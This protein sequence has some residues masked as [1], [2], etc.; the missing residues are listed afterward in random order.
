M[1]DSIKK[2]G[3]VMKANKP[4]HIHAYDVQPDIRDFFKNYATIKKIMENS[5]G[6]DFVLFSELFLISDSRTL[7]DENI[8]QGYKD[9]LNNIKQLAINNDIGISFGCIKEVEREFYICQTVYLPDGRS[10]E[11][12]KT[13]L[14]INERLHFKAGKEM[15][16]FNYKGYN[17]STQICIETHINDLSIVHRKA[18]THIVLAPFRTPYSVE[19]RIINWEKYIPTRGYD[20]NMCFV[21][22]NHNGGKFCV[23]GKGD[24][25]TEITI[26]KNQT[27]L[28]DQSD[29]NSKI[30][31]MSYRQEEL[32]KG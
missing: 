26:G 7:L 24:I 12:L 17:F 30:D 16:Y 18:N 14:G 31:F 19:K 8:L 5:E 10:F 4:L 23:N 21:C 1:D 15:S 6:I 28:I 2:R 27:F 13:H 20:Y 3:L 11:Y 22:C 25:K 29:F 32:Y 9:V